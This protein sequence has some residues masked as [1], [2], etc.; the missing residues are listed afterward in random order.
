MFLYLLA[1]PAIAAPPSNA[2]VTATE[3]DCTFYAL[4][5]NKAGINGVHVHCEWSEL[6]VVS[7]DALL[8]VWENH[9]DYFGTVSVS[10]EMTRE[11]EVARVYQKHVV[12]GISDREVTL[13]MTREVI[14]KGYRYRFTK[15]AEQEAPRESGTVNTLMDDGAWTIVALPR[16]GVSV[17]YDLLYDPG[18]WVPAFIIRWF[19]T[20]GMIAIMGELRTRGNAG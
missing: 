16:G 7:L 8:K 1:L 12:A 4:P 13:D 2:K 3:N 14:D 10:E 20:N 19:Q 11:G 6:T 15:S 17:D 5:K 9:D 18:G